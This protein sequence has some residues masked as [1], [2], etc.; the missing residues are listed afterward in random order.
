[1]KN[2]MNTLHHDPITLTDDFD[3]DFTAEV[4]KRSKVILNRCYHCMSCSNG[5]PF[6]AAMDYLPNAVVRLVQFGLS[7]LVLESSTIWV[8]VNCNRCSSLCPMIVDIP[9]MMSSLRQMAIE[10]KYVVAEPDVLNF[11]K[12]V[13]NSI[14][15]YG[16]VHKL[17]IMLRYKVRK[18]DWFGDMNVGL[19]M[20]SKR[21]LDLAP[22]KVR[23]IQEIKNIFGQNQKEQLNG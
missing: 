4:E 23:H 2:K 1:M 22:S 21:K 10:K 9:S 5:C 16:R 17:E 19:K 6:T 15:R 13:L 18:R 7:Q 14:E 11:H 20:L 3:E 12:E 8:C